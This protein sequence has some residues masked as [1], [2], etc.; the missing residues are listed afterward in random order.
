[1]FSWP[2]GPVGS[3]WW[4]DD[5]PGVSPATWQPTTIRVTLGYPMPDDGS[6][7]SM[8]ADFRVAPEPH[9]LALLGPGAG[10]LGAGLLGATARRRRSRS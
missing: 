3:Q 1:M 5:I 10:L 9:T 6:F 4:M 2:H 7:G 8:Q